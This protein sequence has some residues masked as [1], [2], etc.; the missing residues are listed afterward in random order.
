MI[1]KFN[2]KKAYTFRVGML[3]TTQYNY[4]EV[5]KLYKEQAQMGYSKIL[6]QIAL[7]HSQSSILA[8][9]SFENDVLHLADSMIAPALSSTQSGAS[10]EKNKNSDKSD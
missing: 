7:G 9:I 6:P 1:E 10:T 3:E 5:S 8:T 2:K 4:K